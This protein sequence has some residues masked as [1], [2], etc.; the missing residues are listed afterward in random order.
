MSK[1]LIPIS[2]MLA[3]S[4]GLLFPGIV[5][6]LRNKALEYWSN[7]LELI[8][9]TASRANQQRRPRI[10]SQ[11]FRQKLPYRSEESNLP[12]NM[13]ALNCQIQWTKLE[14]EKSIYDAFSIEICGTINAPS[15][16]CD[17]TL[18]ISIMDVTD[19]PA[20][21]KVVQSQLPQWSSQDGPYPSAFIF[22]VR[23]GRLPSK[24][25]T[26][27]DWTPI[28]QI[29]FDWLMFPRKGK[30][31]LQFITTIMSAEDNQQLA[32]A[33][34]KFAC[35]N[36]F[37]GYIDLQE[38]GERTNILAVALAFAVSAADNELYDCEIE[39][40]KNWAKDNVLESSASDSDEQ[41]LNK[42]LE[43]TIAFFR[44]GNNIDTYKICDEIVSIAPVAQRYDI[45]E[46][47]LYVIQSKGSVTTEELTLLKNMAEW[48][49]VDSKKFRNMM[50]KVL[51][52]DM[53]QVR[54]V[55]TILG[56]T[57]DMSKEKV[58]KH[59]NE[60]YSKW[61]SRVTNADPDIQNQ[62]DQML[63]LIA[64]TRSQYTSKATP[65]S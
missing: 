46:L 39:L 43:K 27:P 3:A 44:A 64:E 38:N 40:I 45:L 34:C 16:N 10:K 65:T 36:P 24:V 14:E 58:R 1:L 54:D 49:D 47:C 31:L 59:L 8:D 2:I 50:E 55:E 37:Y 12:V 28:A 20:N 63:K 60:E 35:E 11:L 42:A 62:A 52:V 13:N 33:Q 53:H 56:I 48:L 7:L 6:R 41:K 29:R 15:D 21:A 4:V 26:M 61:N 25:T 32:L 9:G 5:G 30:R 23:L 51:P 18:Q 17:T 22:N 19:G 57:S